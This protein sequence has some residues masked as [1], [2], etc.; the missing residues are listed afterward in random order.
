MAKNINAASIFF[1]VNTPWSLSV[2]YVTLCSTILTWKESEISVIQSQM[3]CADFISGLFKHHLFTE[4]GGR[5]G[6]DWLVDQDLRAIIH[7]F[8]GHD[9]QGDF[10]KIRL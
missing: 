7:A 8:S 5:T 10:I 6:Y 4:D 2:K 3:I 9:V 1:N